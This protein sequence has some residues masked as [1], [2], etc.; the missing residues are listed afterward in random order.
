MAQFIF[1]YKMDPYY[2][3]AARNLIINVSHYELRYIIYLYMKCSEP[4]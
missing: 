1:V 4:V 2:F 3:V